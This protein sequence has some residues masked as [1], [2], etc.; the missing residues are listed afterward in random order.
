MTDMS[1]GIILLVSI[2]IA[3]SL[4][5]VWTQISKRRN[6]LLIV[7]A[8]LLLSGLLTAETG[9]GIVVAIGGLAFLADYF[10]VKRVI[11]V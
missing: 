3:A 7:G 11:R 5:F 1:L 2:A 9:I 6:L 10:N 4:Y 8:L